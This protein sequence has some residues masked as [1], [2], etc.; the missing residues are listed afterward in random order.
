[1]P[2]LE[3]IVELHVLNEIEKLKIEND[4]LKKWIKAGTDEIYCAVCGKKISSLSMQR[5]TRPILWHDRNCFQQKPRKIIKLESEFGINIVDILKETTRRCGNIKSQCD[6]LGVS[7]PYLYSIIKK[8][9][10]KDHMIFMAKHASG[11]RKELYSKKV[12]KRST[13]S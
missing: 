6:L 13:R 10:G 12:L 8:Y 9:C 4:L 2:N 11:K 5:M 1:M 3:D 7:I